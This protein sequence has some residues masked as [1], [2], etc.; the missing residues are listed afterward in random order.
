MIVGYVIFS[1]S[2][3]SKTSVSVADACATAT[4]KRATSPIGKIRKSLCV[5]AN[6]TLAAPN[7]TVVVLDSNR[8]NGGCPSTMNPSNVNVSCDLPKYDL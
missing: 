3:R 8:K 5:I 4:P 1:T 2:T 6:T 7:A